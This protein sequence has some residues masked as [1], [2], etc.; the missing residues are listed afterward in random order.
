MNIRLLGLHEATT[1]TMN[2]RGNWSSM[3]G[4]GGGESAHRMASTMYTTINTE[5]T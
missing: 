3:D 5:E 1:E 4:E 2:R